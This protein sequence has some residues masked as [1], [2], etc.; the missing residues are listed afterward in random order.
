MA[1]GSKK[2][3]NKL[4]HDPLAWLDNEIIDPVS[5]EVPAD[6]VMI[7]SEEVVQLNNEQQKDSVVEQATGDDV[8]INNESVNVLELPVYFGIA[9]VEEMH[10]SMK[11][12]IEQ[13]VDTVEVKADD[14]ESID[15]AALQLLIVFFQHMKNIGKTIT[16]T[17]LSDRLKAAVEL[18]NIEATF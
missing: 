1:A 11:V 15:A 5:D 2:S 12:I 17:A 18:I 3:K 7:E 14:N 9:Q 4:G 6:D 13:G 16:I 10:K 8:K